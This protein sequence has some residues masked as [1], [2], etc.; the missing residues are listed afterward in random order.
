[1]NTHADKR[2]ESKSQSVAN[3]VSQK[4]NDS[5]S[6]F[7]FVDNRPEAVAQ[8]KL[9]E[10]ANNY[11]AQRQQPIQKK[12]NNTGLPDNL[13]SGIENLSDYSMDDVKVHYNS[14]KPTQLQAHAYAQGTDIHLA[15]G[16][17]KH[18][19]HE[20]WHVVQQKQGRVRPT[21]QMKGGMNVN[22]DAGLEKE[23]DVMGIKSLQ[24]HKNINSVKLLSKG[25]SQKIIQGIWLTIE[26]DTKMTQLQD[27]GDGTYTHGTTGKI[28]ERKPGVHNTVILKST[29]SAHAPMPE[30]RTWTEASTG[31]RPSTPWGTVSATHKRGAPYLGSR[32]GEYGDH[33]MGDTYKEFI[34]ALRSGGKSDVAIATALLNQDASGFTT[35]GEKRGAAMFH[36]TVNLAEEWRKH[37]ASKICRGELRLIKEGKATFDTFIDDF[38]FVE[39]ADAGRHQVARMHEVQYGFSKPEDLPT[40]DRAIYTALSQPRPGDL[41]SDDEERGRKEKAVKKKRVFTRYKPSDSDED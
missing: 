41:S 10:M 36:S 9:Q 16:Q 26:G 38:A 18:L 28:Y 33:P 13:K 6:T 3:A 31:V 14:D 11:S 5:K 39:S 34:K 8:R 21:M 32:A 15:P 7:Q 22:D 29:S 2:Q 17:E 27:N 12:E 23:A 19:P 37:G 4:Q 30:L 35:D 40:R 24:F 25:V 20:A 1:M